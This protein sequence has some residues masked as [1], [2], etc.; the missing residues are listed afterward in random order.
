MFDE[1]QPAV[2]IMAD[3]YRGTIYIGVTG[4]LY[5]RAAVHREGTVPGF[6]AKYGLKHPVWYE[7]HETMDA[8]IKRETQMKAWKRA[9]KIELIEKLNPDWLDLSN[10]LIH[11][12]AT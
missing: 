9:W 1:K 11:R 6:T 4:T 7:N 3:R 10:N 12:P 8:A 2:Y 5:T